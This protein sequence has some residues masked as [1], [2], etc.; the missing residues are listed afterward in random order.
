MRETSA[1]RRV[2]YAGSRDDG[3]ERWADTGG[4]VVGDWPWRS[5]RVREHAKAGER[6]RKK[7]EKEK[8]PG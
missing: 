3:E 2:F 1:K 7:K 6:E 8:L 4:V 5:G